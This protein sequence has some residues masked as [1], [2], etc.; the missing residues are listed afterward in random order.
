MWGL[1]STKRHWG[2][3]APSTSVSPANH[4]HST[5]ISL[6]II[7]RGWHNKPIGGRSAEWTQLDSTPHC[8]NLKKNN[9]ISCSTVILTFF[10]IMLFGAFVYC[11]QAQSVKRRAMSSTAGVRYPAGVRDFSFLYSV[12]AG[13]GARPASPPMGA[14]GCFPGDKTTGAWS[15]LL[16]SRMEDGGAIPPLPHI[17]LAR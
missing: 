9:V 10:I 14:G 6:I 16:T 7:T 12:Q 8:T 4:H 5:N 11:F 2:R 1:W 13:S 3:F 17:F 15:L